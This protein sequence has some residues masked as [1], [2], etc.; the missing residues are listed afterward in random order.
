M[1]A[2]KESASFAERLDGS[3]TSVIQPYR[4]TSYEISSPLR[5]TTILFGCPLPDEV[6]GASIGQ[7]AVAKAFETIL[8][9]AAVKYPQALSAAIYG[10]YKR[11]GNDV[12][13]VKCLAMCPQAMLA[14]VTVHR[15]HSNW[16]RYGISLRKMVVHELLI[17]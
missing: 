16:N 15:Q 14:H 13:L 9:S 1:D 12:K 8:S 4:Y 10:A 7:R 11:Q 2:S 5:P 3:F 17:T 6:D